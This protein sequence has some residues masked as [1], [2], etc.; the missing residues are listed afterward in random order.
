[1]YYAIT[2]TE[3]GTRAVLR[4]SAKE[5]D[6][7]Q[8]GKRVS[9]PYRLSKDIDVLFTSGYV[10]WRG[11]KSGDW[12]MRLK[13]LAEGMLLYGWRE[14]EMRGQ[15]NDLLSHL[16]SLSPQLLEWLEEIET[17]EDPAAFRAQKRSLEI[18]RAL[19]ALRR[20]GRET[21]ARRRDLALIA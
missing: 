15:P 13:F 7:S 11:E 2:K 4:E 17:V 10:D 12:E 19:A 8:I 5:F 18:Q 20:I 21:Y 6:G 9:G 1:M 3:N 14:E 16:P